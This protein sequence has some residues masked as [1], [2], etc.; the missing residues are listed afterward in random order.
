MSE[1]VD[2]VTHKSIVDVVSRCFEQ[3]RLSKS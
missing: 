3:V 2:S 1:L